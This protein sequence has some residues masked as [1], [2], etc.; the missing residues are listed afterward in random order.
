MLERSI[1]FEGLFGDF[2]VWMLGGKAVHRFP[3][4]QVR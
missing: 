3:G 4:S 1:S 2:H